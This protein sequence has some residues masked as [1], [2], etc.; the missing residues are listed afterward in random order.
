MSRIYAEQVGSFAINQLAGKSGNSCAGDEVCRTK[1][2]SGL[3]ERLCSK[4]ASESQDHGVFGTGN[5]IR[6]VRRLGG[7]GHRTIG[8]DGRR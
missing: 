3:L 4:F 1:S 5:S 7:C 6:L 2:R 8:F